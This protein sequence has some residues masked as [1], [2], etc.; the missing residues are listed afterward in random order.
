MELQGARMVELILAQD[1]MEAIIASLNQGVFEQPYWTSFLEKLRDATE[2][3]YASLVFLRADARY[4]EQHVI[5]SGGQV[6]DLDAQ[7]GGDIVAKLRLSYGSLELNRPYTLNEIVR[8]D[9]DRSS[10]YLTYLKARHINHAVVMRVSNAD[11]GSGWLTVGRSEGD[12]ATE[13]GPLLS[14][15]AIH[16]TIAVRILAELERAYMRADIASD[17]AHRLNFGWATFDER[18]GI[19]EIDEL[20]ERLF[21]TMSQGAE[22]GI[23]FLGRDNELRDIIGEYMSKQHASPRTIHLSDEPWLDM[24]L[25]PIAGRTVSGGRTPVAVG[26]VRGVDAVSDERCEQLKR[27]FGLTHSEG[28]LALA[29][30]QGQSIA[31]AAASLNLTVETARN[32]SKR[33]YA[34]TDARGHAD[35]VRIILASVIALT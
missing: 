13:T 11:Q 15:L 3:D 19:I 7:R 35:L 25:L 34:K 32:Y 16:L 18:A 20:T 33:I 12:L 31:A 30:S 6:R 28:R 23:S 29:L 10:E 27:L 21:A 8:E 22:R 5:R 1:E 17:A 4:Q 2:A 9:D 24:L 26:Y 14:R